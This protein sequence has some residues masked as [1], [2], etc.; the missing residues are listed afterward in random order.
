ME[1]IIIVS[2]ISFL[3]GMQVAA[4]YYA[5][6]VREAFGLGEDVSAI[7]YLKTKATQRRI[8][9]EKTREGEQ[10]EMGRR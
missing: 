4:A 6:A 2:I 9:E 5:Q 10:H 1:L 3:I 7:M 8:A